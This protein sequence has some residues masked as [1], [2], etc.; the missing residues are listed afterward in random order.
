MRLYI[1]TRGLAW[2]HHLTAQSNSGAATLFTG[3]ALCTG[4]SLGVEADAATFAFPPPEKKNAAPARLI[5]NTAVIGK[6][7]GTSTLTSKLPPF[8]VNPL[9]FQNLKQDYDNS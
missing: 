6:A 8:F 7:N 1:T 4:A 9:L 3:A 2:L 5:A